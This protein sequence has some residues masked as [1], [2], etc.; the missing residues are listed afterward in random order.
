MEADR[1]TLA[2]INRQYYECL[3]N[4]DV[5][6][7]LK[8][9]RSDE[10]CTVTLYNNEEAVMKGR[11]E[12]DSHLDSKFRLAWATNKNAHKQTVSRRAGVEVVLGRRQGAGC[13]RGVNSIINLD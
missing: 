9:W 4:R 12:I 3:N 5:P 1:T 2:R 11:E 13:H 6:G 7:L 8:L 10:D